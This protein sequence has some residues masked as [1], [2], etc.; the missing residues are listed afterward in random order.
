MPVTCTFREPD[1]LLPG[2]G[3]VT[4]TAKV[5]AERALPVA[6]SFVALT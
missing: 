4:L 2:F 5:P 3:F 1:A 6:V